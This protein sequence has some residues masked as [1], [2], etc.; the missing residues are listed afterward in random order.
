MTELTDWLRAAFSWQLHRP[1]CPSS[2]RHAGA[3]REIEA[4]PALDHEAMSYAPFNKD[5]YEEA[6]AIR[7]MSHQEASKGCLICCPLLAAR[8]GVSCLPAGV[9]AD[10]VASLTVPANHP[11]RW[12]TCGASWACA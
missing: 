2:R 7:A 8:L 1:P 5:F 11:H 9:L 12:P 3:K 10:L 6:A 4:L